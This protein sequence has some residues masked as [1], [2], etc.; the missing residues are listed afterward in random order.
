[1]LL[2]VHGAL[3]GGG[4]S[5][6]WRDQILLLVAKFL[7]LDRVHLLRVWTY[8]LYRRHVLL[9][10]QLTFRLTPWLHHART[11]PNNFQRKLCLFFTNNFF[12]I[13]NVR[14][15]YFRRNVFIRCSS[16]EVVTCFLLLLFGGIKILR[17]IW[18]NHLPILHQCVTLED[19][20]VGWSLARVEACWKSGAFAAGDLG[21]FRSHSGYGGRELTVFGLVLGYADGGE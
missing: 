16:T 3:V 13:S 8:L 4:S 1:M 19:I 12:I 14:L 6:V 17:L 18:H 2:R 20:L 9:R 11:A 5:H 21:N 10:S 7:N 15:C